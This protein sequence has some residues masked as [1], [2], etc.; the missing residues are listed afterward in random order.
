MKKHR[1]LFNPLANSATTSADNASIIESEFPS[2]DEFIYENIIN[3]EDL[4]SYLSSLDKEEDVILA[5]GDG[6]LNCFINSLDGKSVSTELLYYPMGSGNDFY[7]DVQTG[8]KLIH[9]NKYIES[10]P[11]ITVN[12]KTYRFIN[13]IGYGIDGYCCEEGDKQRSAGKKNINYT[14]I[15]IKGLLFC[16]KPTSAVVTVD[17]KKYT[18]ENVWLA[19]SMI[20]RYYGGGMIV[21]PQQDRL[22]DNKELS[23]VIYHAKSKIKSLMVF[24]SIF[25]GKHVEHKDIVS[26]FTGKQ[27]TVSFDRPT[28]LQIDGETITGVTT[29]TVNA[30]K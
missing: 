23:L 5:G 9:L 30:A 24:P 25:K 7:S 20:G 18:F 13:G 10:L 1:I 19:P 11:T 26:V 12:S 28:P 8:S 15:A 6:T 16:Y 22:N 27:I 29:Y 17:E 3:I 14:N 21:A 4:H 2:E